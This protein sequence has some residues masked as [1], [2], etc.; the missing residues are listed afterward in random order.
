MALCAV[1]RADACPAVD[2]PRGTDGPL[3]L[4]RYLIHLG[5]AAF[6]LDSREKNNLACGRASRAHS[7]RGGG[8]T[9]REM[10]AATPP[11][12][13][14]PPLPSRPRRGGR[15]AARG[16]Q[17][18]ALALM[19]VLF[20]AAGAAAVWSFVRPSTDPWVGVG[21]IEYFPPGSVTSFR[22][23]IDTDGR[24]GFHI[25]RLDDGELLAL[26]DR[27]PV[28]GHPVPYRPEFVWDGR[29]GWFRHHAETFDMAGRRVFGPQPR[30]LDRLAVEVRNGEVY[31]NPQAITPGWSAVTPRDDE[32]QTGG[33]LLSP[34]RY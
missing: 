8:R 6:G 3:D 28:Y 15:R 2:T 27:D 29:P 16:W 34:R 1:F 4:R 17:R 22:A 25:V 33:V 32:L 11:P 12:R 24:E 14:D 5:V 23:F 19:L 13:T 21:L 18:I 30:N 31:V 9:I 26:R 7:D 20:A 10:V